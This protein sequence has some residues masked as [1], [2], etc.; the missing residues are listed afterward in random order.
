MEG[1]QGSKRRTRL[2]TTFLI[3]YIVIIA[4]AA[5]L[6]LPTYWY[7]WLI[8]TLIGL[9]RIASWYMPRTTYLCSNCGKEFIARRGSSLRPA[10]DLYSGTT[11]TKCPKCGSTSWTKVT[12]RGS[13]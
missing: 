8:I 5:F 13:K 10:A 3:A 12:R 11:K 4:V 7:L 6:L 9:F 1:E 2:K